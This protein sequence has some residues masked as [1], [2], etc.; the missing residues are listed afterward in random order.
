MGRKQLYQQKKKHRKTVPKHP[1][2]GIPNEVT[3]KCAQS[4]RG[5][6]VLFS[7]FILTTSIPFLA[8]IGLDDAEDSLFIFLLIGGVDLFFLNQI[9]VNCLRKRDWA[10]AS[11]DGLELHI[12]DTVFFFI[13]TDTIIPWQRISQFASHVDSTQNGIVS[14]L[15]LKLEGNDSILQY[16]IDHLQGHGRPLLPAISGYKQQAES[17]ELEEDAKEGATDYILLGTFFLSLLLLWILF[18]IVYEQTLIPYWFYLPFVGISAFGAILTYI[19]LKK[20]M[21]RLFLG[22]FSLA[23]L[24]AMG[25]LFINLCFAKWNVP[26]KVK[27][28]KVERVCYEEND[29]HEKTGYTVRIKT[30]NGTKNLHFEL[31]QDFDLLKATEVDL[32]LHQG[33][34]GFPVYKKK[35]A[36]TNVTTD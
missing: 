34:F 3:L 10:K 29:D 30:Q 13:K 28:F 1:D 22:A 20:K 8:A 7:I 32:Y 24:S 26:D 27:T 11:S 2:F 25:F 23:T 4:F 16:H 12:H 36:R 21:I 14:L 6:F 15:L 5:L 9:I 19:T 18:P 31:E 35:V 33:F 17:K